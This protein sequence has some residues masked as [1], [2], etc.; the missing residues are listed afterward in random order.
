MGRKLASESLSEFV[1]PNK[2][3]PA[4]LILG[5]PLKNSEH[6][7]RPRF[8]R[9]FVLEP[10]RTQNPLGRR[11]HRVGKFL[12]LSTM[13]Q[14]ACS[15]CRPGRCLTKPSLDAVLGE[16]SVVRSGFTRMVLFEFSTNATFFFFGRPLLLVLYCGH[17]RFACGGK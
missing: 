9:P 16:R 10:P 4:L 3:V 14:S 2:E 11:G 5:R 13:K 17:C 12:T 1:R 8:Q 7:G 15:A 6:L